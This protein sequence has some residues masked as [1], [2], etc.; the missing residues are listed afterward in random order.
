M[1]RFSIVTITWNAAHCVQKTLDSVAAQTYNCLEH[2]IIDGVSTDETLPMVER[3]RQQSSYPV[4]IS[5]EP[6]T[7]IYDAMN[8]GLARAAG[9]YVI[10][11][12]AGDCFH[13]EDILRQIVEQLDENNL[14]AVIYGNTDIVDDTGRYLGKRH[15]SAPE[16]LT[17]RSF[18][19]GMLVCHQ[20]FYARTDI[21]KANRYDES[22]KLSGDVDWCIRV[23]KEAEEKGLALHNTH[24][25]LAD[26]LK[27]GLSTHHHRASLK[28]RFMVMRRHYGLLTT[29]CWHCWFLLR[30]LAR[31]FRDNNQ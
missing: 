10:F 1:I 24:M 26:Y 18:Q 30:A 28:E 11:M 25:V 6:D 14:P 20:A 7:G 29:L 15:L 8:K 22:L 19:K 9:D 2:L 5:S 27:E 21:A 13:S 31:K 12:N 16:H 17:W 23:M 3:Y 4:F